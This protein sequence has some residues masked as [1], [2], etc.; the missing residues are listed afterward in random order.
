MTMSFPLDGTSRLLNLVFSTS[1][2]AP[3]ARSIRP[4]PVSLCSHGSNPLTHR[5]GQRWGALHIDRRVPPLKGLGTFFVPI[6]D[7][8]N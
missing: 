2:S 5:L 7:A 4:M 8:R 6:S 3:P 1:V